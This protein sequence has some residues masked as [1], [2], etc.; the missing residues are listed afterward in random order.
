MKRLPGGSFLKGLLAGCVGDR[1]DPNG[2][3]DGVVKS[4]SSA[5]SRHLSQEVVD[6][7][8]FP[9]SPTPKRVI[10]REAVTDM[11]AR[12]SEAARRSRVCG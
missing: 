7:L 12:I 3:D 2:D 4:L 1:G 10:P 6:E 8:L 9:S 5:S 11:D